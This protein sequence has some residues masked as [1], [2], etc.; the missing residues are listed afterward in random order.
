[1]FQRKSKGKEHNSDASKVNFCK[2]KVLCE[3]AKD[4][5]QSHVDA[6]CKETSTCKSEFVS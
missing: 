2:E 6:K 5:M 1:M 3:F 4:T